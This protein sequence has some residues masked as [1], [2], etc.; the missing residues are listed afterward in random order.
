[1]SVTPRRLYVAGP[2]TGLPDL[3]YPAFTVAGE[4]LAAAGYVPLLPLFPA[5][6]GK[7]WSAY[8]RD[9]LQLL[10]NA[11]QGV[12][13]LP[14]WGPSRGASLEV[15]TANQTGIPV[16]TVAE[17]CADPCP[18]PAPTAGT[19]P[20]AFR[21]RPGPEITAIRWTGPDAT[22]AVAEM[23]AEIRAVPDDPTRIEV[24]DYLHRSWIG[25]K[26]GDW[27]VCG[28]LGE[29][30]PVVDWAF[31][32]RYEPATEPAATDTGQTT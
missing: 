27:I 6:D 11:A 5:V 9:A 17:W 24:Y 13:T 30:Y 10:F 12:A 23:G 28:V 31:T 29:F 20:T 14:G 8:M 21:L 16:R 1:M 3:N 19:A 15:F 2:M 22:P 26:P 18:P 25:V 32:M 4:E 7:P